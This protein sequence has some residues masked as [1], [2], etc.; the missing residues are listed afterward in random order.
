M[1]ASKLMVAI[2]AGLMV[3]INVHLLA[4]WS[5]I[6]IVIGENIHHPGMPQTASVF[7]IAMLGIM[8]YVSKAII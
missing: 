2:I 4:H 1:V 6:V 3:A 5:S 7:K 8:F